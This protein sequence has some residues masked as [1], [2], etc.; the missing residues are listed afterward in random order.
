M[1]ALVHS[2][3]TFKN[4]LQKH[5]QEITSRNMLKKHIQEKL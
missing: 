5:I 1:M 3:T 2:W 4:T